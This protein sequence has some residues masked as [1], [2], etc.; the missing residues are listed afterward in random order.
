[1]QAATIN[2]IEIFYFR[3]LL[4][5][6]GISHCVTSR[7]GG[8]S[9]GLYSSLNMS[10]NVGDIRERVEQNRQKVASILDIGP[11]KLLIPSQCHTKNVKQISQNTRV[12]DLADTDAL[13]TNIKGHALAVLGA[14]C[15]PVIIYDPVEQAI[16]AV[17]AGWKGTVQ[18]IVAA[19][20]EEMVLN[21]NS[22]PKNLFAGIGPCISTGMYEVGEEVASGFGSLFGDNP[23]I[24]Q[25][26]KNTDK[27]HINLQEANRNQLMQKGVLPLNIEMADICTY[28]HPE[29]FFSARRDGAK[30]GRFASIILL[31]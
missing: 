23:L 6:K 20:I 11:E 15:V 28:N 7:K 19:T 1:M 3:N 27:F 26:G 9:E 16:A 22:K 25:P 17:H 10:F 31:K 2:G 29:W 8:F 24:V 12:E 30:C 4:N 21:Y 14:D 5:S 18:N 13:I